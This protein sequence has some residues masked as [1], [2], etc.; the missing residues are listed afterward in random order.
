M[1][2]LNKKVLDEYFEISDYIRSIADLNQI[3]I[4]QLENIENFCELCEFLDSKIELEEFVYSLSGI[5]VKKNNMFGVITKDVSGLIYNK[6]YSHENFE[7]WGEALYSAFEGDFL[8]SF[9]IFVR[10]AKNK[11]QDEFI[12]M[13]ETTMDSIRSM[14]QYLKYRIKSVN[15]DEKISRV[16][17]SIKFTAEHLIPNEKNAMRV[18][19]SLSN[20]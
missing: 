15:N 11:E 5:I 1:P 13:Q 8:P 2:K 7:T 20:S 6:I 18:L 14:H 4:F 12:F 19:E 17:N 10:K 9:I 16:E 3:T